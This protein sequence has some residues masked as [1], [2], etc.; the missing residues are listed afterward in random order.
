MEETSNGGSS[1][2]VYMYLHKQ[3]TQLGLSE[4]K[5][6]G[7][8]PRANYTNRTSAFRRRSYAEFLATD[9]EARVLF[10]RYQIF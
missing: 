8:S 1:A 4:T 3:H 2:I 6:R 5:L 7:L 10:Q 9:A